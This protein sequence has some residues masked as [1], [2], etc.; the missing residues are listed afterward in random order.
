MSLTATD[1][2]SS[3][4]QASAAR[5]RFRLV[6]HVRYEETG[7]SEAE[8]RVIKQTQ[9]KGKALSTV[10]PATHSTFFGAVYALLWFRHHDNGQPLRC[11]TDSS[12]HGVLALKDKPRGVI[13]IAPWYGRAAGMTGLRLWRVSLITVGR[14]HRGCAMGVQI[15]AARC[16]CIYIN[17]YAFIA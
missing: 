3:Q 1:A 5:P 16:L 7:G 12:F 8:K 6:Y 13:E 9:G 14:C 11:G 17:V 10:R 2:P 15:R 4:G